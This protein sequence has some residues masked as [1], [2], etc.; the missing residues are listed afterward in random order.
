MKVYITAKFGTD[1][2]KEIDTLC[3]LV[4]KS[5]FEDYCFV[6]DVDEKF[7]D[8]HEL[9]RR[10][11]EEIV[12]CDVLLIHYDGPG[13]GR[14]VELGIA[15]ALDKKIILITKE[16]MFIKET[17]LGVTDAVIE[18]NELEDI[19]TPLAQIYSDWT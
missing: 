9:M 18:Y 1:N 15:Y 12:A 17:I 11:K 7:Q 2:K 6:R 3:T 8:A 16:G 5:G 4:Q 10:A 13:H 14:I 19:V